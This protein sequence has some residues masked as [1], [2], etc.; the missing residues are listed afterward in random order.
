MLSLLDTFKQVEELA[1]NIFVKLIVEM[2]LQHLPRKC[3]SNFN[4]IYYQNINGTFTK[5]SRVCPNRYIAHFSRAFDI[6][7]SFTC[8][9][10]NLTSH[11][12]CLKWWYARLNWTVIKWNQVMFSDDSRFNLDGH[13]NLVHVWGPL[14]ECLRLA[15]CLQQHI[16]HTPG[17]KALVAITCNTRSSLILI[18]NIFTVQGQ[19]IPCIQTTP[20]TAW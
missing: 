16:I 18:D 6:A 8:A 11:Q 7:V 13:Y 12:L 17:L 20:L 1:Q 5:G 2:Q 3:R 4:T 9:L 10:I 15:L 14:A 19:F